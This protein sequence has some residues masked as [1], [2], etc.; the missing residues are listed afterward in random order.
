MLGI[1]ALYVVARWS[2]P[3]WLAEDGIRIEFTAVQLASTMLVALGMALAS[4][5]IP[6][7]R[8]SRFSIRA[9]VLGEEQSKKRPIG[10]RDY[11]QSHPQPERLVDLGSLIIE[12]DVPEEFIR[13]VR[14][15]APVTIIPLADP[16]RE[17]Y[18]TVRQI[19]GMA[20]NRSGETIVPVQVSIDDDRGYLL[21]NFNVDVT[22][23]FVVRAPD[24]V[25]P[26]PGPDLGG[27][28]LPS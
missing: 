6:I 23:G 1:G 10:R 22:I 17:S 18:G 8:A 26:L 12:A 14:L 19:A 3:A 28:D 25:R 16:T 11:R 27:E 7:L 5:V 4:S 9:L 15:G 2:T 20:V 24:R 21:P 13:D